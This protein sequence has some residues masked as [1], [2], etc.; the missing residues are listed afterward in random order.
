MTRAEWEAEAARLFIERG[1]VTEDQAP[2]LA[3]MAAD[4]QDVRAEPGDFV[5]EWDTPDEA[6]AT[7]MS[8]W[9]DR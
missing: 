4:L 9:D 7:E 6:V 8:Y 5:D 3:R 1:N 2:S